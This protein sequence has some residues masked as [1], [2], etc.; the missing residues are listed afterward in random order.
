MRILVADDDAVYRSLLERLLGE[1]QFD[2]QLVSDGV[3]AMEVMSGSDPPKL[4]ILDW[5]MPRMD[6]FEVARAV[7]GERR[8]AGT[9]I[10]LITGTRNKQDV[11]QVLVSGADDYLI[12]PFDPMDL[13]VHLR[14]AMRV[15][16]L[17]QELEELKEK[18]A[19]GAKS[20]EWRA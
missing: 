8:T 2:V 15:L 19:A 6:G 4:L 5:D 14:G 1:W 13:K 3:E 9:Y 10:L 16:E 18:L 12:K 20:A 7:R 17:Q 11:M